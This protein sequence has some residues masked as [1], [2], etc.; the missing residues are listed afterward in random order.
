MRASLNGLPIHLRKPIRDLLAAGGRVARDGSLVLIDGPEAMVEAL[1]AHSEELVQHVVPSVGAEE[2]E[3]VRDLLADAGASVAYVTSPQNGD[4]SNSRRPPSL[5]S[6][7]ESRA[8]EGSIPSRYD[9]R[10]PFP[11]AP[12][13][14]RFKMPLMRS[15]QMS[16]GSSCICTG[17]IAPFIYLL[18]FFKNAAVA[19]RASRRKRKYVGCRVCTM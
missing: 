19:H 9:G 6:S 8:S 5:Q 4:H 15:T 10:V 3:L 2:A 18:S 7:Q 17:M 13:S 11:P 16:L 14:D 1:R 12:N